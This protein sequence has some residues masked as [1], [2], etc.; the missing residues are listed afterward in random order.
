MTQTIPAVPAIPTVV[1]LV[2]LAVQ[3]ARIADALPAAIEE[4]L[5][6][7]AF[8]LGPQVRRFEDEYSA[9]CGIRHTLGVGNG[10]DALVLAL[11]GAGIGPG[12][13]VIVPANTF[14]ATAEAVA[15]VGADLVLADCDVHFLIDVSSVADR[16]TSR[17]RAVIG[18]DLY[19]QVADF[20]ALES[21]VGQEVHLFEDA[22]QSQG[23]HRNG[24]RSGS[25]GTAAATSFYPGK[26]L[27]A[28]GD[29]GAV[30][31][32]RDDVAEM[33]RALRNH[34]GVARYEHLYVGTNSRLDSLQAAILSL[35]LAQLEDWNAERRQAAAI[36]GDLLADVPGLVLPKVL[37]GNVP[38]WH[39]YVVRVA[40]RDRVISELA[41][42]G[43]HAGIHYPAP[44]HLLPAFRH[45]GLGAGSFPVAEAYAGEQLSLPI[46]PGIT[47]QQQAWVAASLLRALGTAPR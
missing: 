45:L 10:T 28:Y 38:V 5:S 22:A 11:R 36:Y 2:D 39:L 13:E 6:T 41:S 23:A 4:V 43:V 46:Y 24:R 1:P 47:E 44:I 18:V 34:G 30:T 32:N 37:E 16:I 15:L 35:K 20:E 40:E 7:T 14:V 3:H 42:A 26:N 8:V 29:A 33:I 17:T 9:F 25:F 31:T 12:D 21:V 19:G 27:G